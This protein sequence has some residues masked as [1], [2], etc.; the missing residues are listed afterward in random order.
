MG[1]LAHA[2]GIPLHHLSDVEQSLED[3]Y[4]E[5][6]G[7][8]VEFR[9]RERREPTTEELGDHAPTTSRPHVAD[10][11]PR[12]LARTCAAEWTRLWTVRAT[13]WFLAAAAVVMVGLGTLA[14]FEAAADP[15]ELAGEPAWATAQFTAMPAQFALLAW[16]SPR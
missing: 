14:G 6:T 8:S 10:V 2:C 1:E 4:L 13:W 16:P 12:V 3:A 15:V 7:S 9:G 5:L 11:P